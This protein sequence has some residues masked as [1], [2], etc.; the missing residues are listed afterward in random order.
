MRGLSTALV[1]LGI[2]VGAAPSLRATT[3]F[4]TAVTS[5]PC[6][7][8]NAGQG[9]DANTRC[10]VDPMG[11]FTVMASAWSTTG[12]SGGH[13]GTLQTAALGL[14]T[15]ATPAY[16]LG[17]CN[18]YE[19]SG[20]STNGTTCTS[21]G[22][23]PEH[24]IDNSVN[25][26]FVLLTLSQP[27]VTSL[28]FQLSTFGQTKDTDLTYFIGNCS[29]VCN[30]VNKTVNGG[31]TVAG[32]FSAGEYATGTVPGP[33]VNTNT[34]GLVAVDLSSVLGNVQG[35]VNWI[36]IGAATNSSNDYFKLTSMSF[37]TGAYTP[38]PATFGL[39]GAALAAMGLLRARKKKRSEIV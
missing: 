4:Y 3:A 33:T 16:G 36:L 14:Y 13:T 20:A 26:D 17:V 6:Q 21:G 11:P 32:L 7:T 24:P 29:G 25:Y 5:G 8:G 38:E 34:N 31:T 35:G 22:S 30:P 2:C 10:F 18:D 37:T 1:L 39:A 27:A 12:G 23:S 28:S 9:T 19:R 15:S